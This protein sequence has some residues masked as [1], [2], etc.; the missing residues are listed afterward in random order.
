[1]NM[2][3]IAFPILSE[4]YLYGIVS[5]DKPHLHVPY[6]PVAEDNSS[7][8]IAFLSGLGKK[9]KVPVELFSVSDAGLGETLLKNK[10]QSEF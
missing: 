9:Y 8:V 7:D 1:M 10:F 6:I 5:E 3:G 4:E 2:D